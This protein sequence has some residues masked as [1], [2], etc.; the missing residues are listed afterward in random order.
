MRKCVTENHSIL[1]C[2][3]V[4]WCICW[5]G[6]LCGRILGPHIANKRSIYATCPLIFNLFSDLCLLIADQF[7]TAMGPLEQRV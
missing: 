4:V 3:R 2:Y 7:M 5:A 6:V 1:L